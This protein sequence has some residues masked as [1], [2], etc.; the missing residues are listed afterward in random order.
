M[1][2]VRG[3]ES[4][5]EFSRR[6]DFVLKT[7]QVAL[8]ILVI[9]I[10]SSEAEVKPQLVSTLDG[11][12]MIAPD[13]SLWTWGGA[14]SPRATWF[15][16]GRISE[17]PWRVGNDRDWSKIASKSWNFLAL[18]LDGSLWGWGWQHT[19]QA[20]SADVFTFVANPTR[21][22]SSRDWREIAA[23][24]G[25]CLALKND[26]SLWSWG[27]NDYG[28]LGDETGYR[29]TPKQVGS[30]TNWQSIAAGL[31]TS[32]GLKQDGTIW[33]CGE[34]LALSREASLNTSF[35]EGDKPY[36]LDPGTNWNAIA[37]GDFFLLALKSDGTLWISGPNARSI[38]SDC[39]ERSSSGG[40]FQVGKKAD[41]AEIYA[42]GGS[43]FARKRS[44]RWFACGHN[45]S[46]QLGL[47][48]E[49]VVGSLERLFLD[50]DP[51]AFAT[52]SG[53][54]LLLAKNGTLLTWGKRLGSDPSPTA[55]TA[56]E[57][58]NILLRQPSQ[59]RTLFD[60]ARFK[61]DSTPVKLWELPRDTPR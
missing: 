6:R 44:G 54:T 19:K 17:V 3:R 57:D 12:L 61:I 11:A 33:G 47:G 53:N 8:G 42:G 31:F 37:A 22:D 50:V 18:K 25:H 48:K 46:Q 7:V 34:E 39:L 21:I 45:S 43:F 20:R 40:F 27:R 2:P 23:G 15:G 59:G 30:E 58:P 41:W 1:A 9:G 14:H 35:I 24:E 38:C 51:W 36:Q 28:Q 56:Q 29:A 16:D 26:R 5:G 32:F 60:T 13:S 10:A 52:G 49:G 4:S 55:I